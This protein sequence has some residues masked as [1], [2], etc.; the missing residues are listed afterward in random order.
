[1]AATGQ[2]TA[3]VSIVA[4][5]AVILATSFVKALLDQGKDL[6]DKKSEMNKQAKQPPAKT[7]HFAEAGSPPKAKE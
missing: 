1:V 3:G 2:P 5:T 4:A 6:A 7:D